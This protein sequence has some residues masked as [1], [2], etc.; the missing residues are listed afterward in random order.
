MVTF[1][2]I[3]AVTR[4]LRRLCLLPTHQLLLFVAMLHISLV[5]R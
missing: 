5:G 3:G 2:A 4:Y 1:N